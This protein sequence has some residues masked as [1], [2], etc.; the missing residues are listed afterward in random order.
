MT[1]KLKVKPDTDEITVPALDQAINDDVER[2]FQK[3]DIEGLRELR[4]R[5]GKSAPVSIDRYVDELT[6]KQ[7]EK[8]NKSS[9]LDL[10]TPIAWD[11]AVDG[12]DVLTDVAE[13]VQ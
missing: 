13:C 2:L 8:P 4:K 9:G 10:H 7:T 11:E 12:A 6:A 3:N 5:F 1:S